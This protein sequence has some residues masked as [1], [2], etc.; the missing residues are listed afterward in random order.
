MYAFDTTGGSFNDARYSNSDVDKLLLEAREATSQAVRATY[1]RQA[2]AII[3]HQAP[4]IFLA[5][6]PVIQAW[7]STV[8][9][10]KVYPD[11]LLRLKD[12]WVK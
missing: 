9:G 1:Y 5:Y 11:G 4:Y 7:S 3:L 12:V 2:E 6:P 8:H 10:Y